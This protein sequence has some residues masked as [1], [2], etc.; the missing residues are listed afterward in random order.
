M[1]HQGDIDTAYPYWDV[2]LRS[3]WRLRFDLSRRLHDLRL[4]GLWMR[5]RARAALLFV[6]KKDGAI[7]MVIDGRKAFSLHRR[8]PA[9]G[10]AA[11]A[12]GAPWSRV[13]IDARRAAGLHASRR[14]GL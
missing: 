11:G 2:R 12:H 9:V 3:S 7:R 5:C 8:P 1:V 13:L 4:V 14:A 6:C 10:L